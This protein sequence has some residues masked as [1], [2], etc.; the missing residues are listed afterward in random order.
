M[1]SWL[2]SV[3][4]IHAMSKGSFRKNPGRNLREYPAGD[5]LK[6]SWFD[7]VEFARK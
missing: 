7:A 5:E 1:N 4:L 6:L 3:I 2:I